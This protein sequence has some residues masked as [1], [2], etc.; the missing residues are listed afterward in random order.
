M[1]LAILATLLIVSLAR[2]QSVIELRSSAHIAPGAAV[3][4]A[5]VA[6]LDGVDALALAGLVLPADDRSITLDEVR[7]AAD[8][9]GRV[10]W[11]RITLRGS[12][13]EIQAPATA[14]KPEPTKSAPLAAAE[15]TPPAEGSLRALVVARIAQSLSVDPADLRP[16]FESRDDAFLDQPTTGKT[17]E[18]RPTASADRIPLSIILYEHNRIASER[19]IR[20]EV[21]VR[22]SVLVASAPKNK[23]DMLEAGDYSV[24]TQWLPP[25]ARPATAAQVQGV[26]VRSRLA[27]GQLIT[28]DTVTPALAVSKGEIVAIRCISGGVIVST[29]ARALAPARDGE[30]VQFQALDSKRTFYAR[31]DGRGRAILAAGPVDEPAPARASLPTRG[32]SI[33][34]PS[35]VE[36]FK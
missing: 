35:S 29:R 25:T 28:T 3:T 26:Q 8:A 23:G 17:V 10:N 34:P 13:C 1:K 12:T 31:M 15:F 14:P 22:R 32:E 4:L 11:G 27:P 2:G 24:E 33:A 18:I 16:T 6:H 36:V 21:L 7:K 9:A 19:S 30:T 5:Q 20:V